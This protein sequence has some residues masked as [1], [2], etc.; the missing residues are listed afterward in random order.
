[1]L[2]RLLLPALGGTFLVSF[3]QMEGHFI[4]RTHLS[5]LVPS[6]SITEDDSK[7]LISSDFSVHSEVQISKG[8]GYSRF[9]CSLKITLQRR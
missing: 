5:E 6:N 9:L 1:M 4:N 8:R 3:L 7:A 2:T